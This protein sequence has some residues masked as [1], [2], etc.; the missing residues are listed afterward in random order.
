MPLEKVKQAIRAMIINL[1]KLQLSTFFIKKPDLNKH[2]IILQIKLIGNLHNILSF[3][4]L[5]SK[6]ISLV[7]TK[8][9]I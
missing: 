8:D 9:V 3:V 7:P 6:N 5:I 1:K 2:E 4:S